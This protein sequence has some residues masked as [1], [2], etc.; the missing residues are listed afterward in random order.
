[1]AS[2]FTIA[3]G[4]LTSLSPRTFAIISAN[5]TRI[6]TVSE[7]EIVAAMRFVWERLKFVVE[8]SAAV[9]VAVAL[10]GELEGRRV[11]IVL[12]GGNV[13]LSH[14]PWSSSPRSDG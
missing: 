7:A 6:A 13:D 2:D 9:G 10:R 1:M 3:D 11:G 14:L 12:T 8:P 5:V 4:L